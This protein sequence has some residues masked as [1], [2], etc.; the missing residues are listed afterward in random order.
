MEHY[1]PELGTPVGNLETP[2][3]L[4]D[5]DALDHNFHIMSDTYKDT[6]CKL[7]AH[8]KNIKSPF[9][10]HEQIRLGGTVGGVC[11]AK[12]SEAEVMIDGGIKDILIP[13]QIVTADKISRLCGL[14]KRADL[15][16]AI[17]NIENVRLISEIAEIQEVKIGVVVEV[18]TQMQR[19]G[20]RT[21]TQAV[22]LAKIANDLPGITFK[23]VMCHQTPE[24]MPDRETRYIQ[25]REFI[26][27]ALDA[28]QAIEDSGITVEIVSAGET[29][30]YDLCAD[31]PGV[32]E[33]EG[34]TYALMSH[35]YNYMDEFQMAGVILGTIISKPDNQIVIGDTGYKCLGSPGGIL[36]KVHDVPN[37]EVSE[38]GPDHIV[39]HDMSE[40][41]LNIGDRYSL[42]P[43]QQDIM[44]NRWDQFIGIR[45]GLVECVLDIP[46]RGCHN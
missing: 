19:A 40:N 7:R 23:G 6:A 26:Q 24:G 11:T 22:E 9:L 8:T 46:G 43:G 5:M 37:V 1:R 32:T 17:D 10:A 42:V 29:W 30:T 3:L 18:D 21:T 39:L 14:A 16:V 13:N 35:P 38:L 15:T 36:P 12:I 31:I 20:V 41:G 34:G 27:T 33:V 2:C 44:V 4:I 25:G 45:N 28:K